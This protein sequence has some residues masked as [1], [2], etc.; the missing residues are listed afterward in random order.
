MNADEDKSN[1]QAELSINNK[2]TKHKNEL[3]YHCKQNLN[4]QTWG[5]KY[6]EAWTEGTR[7]CKRC[8]LYEEHAIERVCDVWTLGL[9]AG[10]C[11]CGWTGKPVVIKEMTISGGMFV[12]AALV[13]ESLANITSYF[14]NYNKIHKNKSSKAREEQHES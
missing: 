2:E 13:T 4:N 9:L 5:E 1:G 8:K 3:C 11:Y 12:A 6:L 14:W 7:K 10:A